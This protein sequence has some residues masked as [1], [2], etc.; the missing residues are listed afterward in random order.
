M[1]K[2]KTVGIITMHKV[3]NCGS[4][5]QA[6]ALQ[7]VINK[8]GYKAELIDYIFPNKYH[9]SI[10]KV[11][12]IRGQLKKLYG[13]FRRMYGRVHFARFYRKFF[14]LSEKTY[15][16][17][18]ELKLS[19][20]IYDIYVSGSD[21][22]WN[23]KYIGSDTSYMLSWVKKG[24]KVAYS[25]S[26][27]TT[28]ISDEY[29]AV[30]SKALSS[31]DYLSV[32]EERSLHL[33]EKVSGKPVCFVLDPALLL[34]PQEWGEVI[35]DSDK[36]I[37]GDY[38]L[39]YLLGYSFNLYPY[40]FDLVKFVY[41][42]YRK[43]LVVLSM[44]CKYVFQL[45]RKTIVNKTTPQNFLSLISNASLV[46]T[47]SFHASAM[48]LNFQVPLYA[49]IDNKCSD[50]NRVYSLLSSMHAEDRII[51]KGTEFE[52]LPPLLADYKEL[53]K[54]LE[55]VRADSLLF[56]EESLNGINCE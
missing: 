15:H 35:A 2:K 54:R 22:V 18:E 10:H 13:F 32:R 17:M 30:Y 37:E 52:N 11:T 16:T 41:E 42:K 53:S 39:I 9:K 38:I 28:T 33:L 29:N 45:K 49:L 40:A 25:G 1:N 43:K 27:A 21:Q 6:Y 19:P 56:L 23:S 20:P 8:M 34:T 24:K 51:V 3:I 7:Y 36:K 47:D 5:L 4:A 14:T 12:G 46:I 44:S 31:Y 55:T 48:A 26:F 50:D